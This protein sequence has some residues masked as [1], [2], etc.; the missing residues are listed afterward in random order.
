MR[1]ASWAA[2]FRMSWVA[3]LPFDG[4]S[5]FDQSG[6]GPMGHCRH[7]NRIIAI[8]QLDLDH[9]DCHWVVAKWS[10]GIGQPLWRRAMMAAG[11][12]PDA[13]V[14]QRPRPAPD[15]HASLL[16]LPPPQIIF[17][18]ATPAP[19]LGPLVW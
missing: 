19:G 15:A 10:I 8:A 1:Y 4:S 2:V 13:G 9:G 7:R 12:R 5:H 18:A 14:P 17:C 3:R 6:Y 16:K 11:R